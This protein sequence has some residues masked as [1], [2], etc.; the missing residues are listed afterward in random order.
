MI[1]TTMR[2]LKKQRFVID[3]IPI[4][5][6]TWE[7][8][9]DYMWKELEKYLNYFYIEYDEQMCCYNIYG[10]KLGFFTIYEEML[11]GEKK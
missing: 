4:Y 2:E 9:G 11:K 8:I 5:K 7:K 1:V 10:D 6:E 3:K